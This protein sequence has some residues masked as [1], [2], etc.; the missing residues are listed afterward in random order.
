MRWN[1][2]LAL[3]LATALVAAFPAAA[4]TAP[5]PDAAKPENPTTPAPAAPAPA[6]TPAP[7]EAPKKPEAVPLA[8][9]AE[10]IAIGPGGYLKLGLLLQAW[11]Q[12]R[13]VKDTVTTAGKT[14]DT[15]TNA[16][17]LRRA[18]IHLKGELVPKRL[19]YGLMIDPSKLME[20]KDTTVTVDVP[21][22]DGL[23]PKDADGYLLGADGKQILGSDGKPMK[24]LKGSTK[25][26]QGPSTYGIL[27][28]FWVGVLTDYADIAVG[29]FKIPVS[30]EGFNSSGALLFAE[31]ALA[32]STF[33]D[34]RDLGLKIDKRFK[35]FYYNVSLFN[36]AGA[37]TFEFDH[38]KDLAARIEVT[39]LPWLMFGGVAYA[40]LRPHGKDANA[41]DR[42]EADVRLDTHGFL[43]QAEYIYA[44]DWDAT[45]KRLVPGHGFYA[46]A[47][48]SFVPQWQIAAR[49]GMLDED[50]KDL[51]P[52]KKTTVWE[53]GAGLH[54]MALG[55]NANLKLDYSFFKPDHTTDK[56]KGTEHQLVLAGQV[57]F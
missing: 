20:S 46:A 49:G 31:R 16:L 25:V 44:R 51:D 38:R 8:K 36:G 5:A 41:K 2:T 57:R 52:K 6:A 12:V 15:W 28:D 45:L 14:K 21:V 3:S 30:Y 29:Q 13:D 27:Q 1:P 43:F 39:P 11:Y 42:F 24:S 48:Y 33:G 9:A 50:L 23:L 4:Q 53:F 35:Y 17:K 37:N 10:G 19:S 34:K 18:E 54:W 32:S 22:P 56:W 47:A 40:T 55:H 7:A 26:K